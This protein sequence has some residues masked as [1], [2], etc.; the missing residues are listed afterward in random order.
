MGKYNPT[1]TEQRRLL[2]Q[3]LW[4]NQNGKCKSCQEY[5]ELDKG[6]IEHA[7]GNTA[8][9]SRDNITFACYSC[10]QRKRP[11]NVL[12]G[13]LPSGI[14]EREKT[15]AP[16]TDRE[17][18]AER[19]SM[20]KASKEIKIN[21]DGEPKFRVYLFEQVGR[22][23]GLTWDDAIAEGAE[24]C[25]VSPETIADR[26][27]PKAT[28]RFSPFQK[29]EHNT[30]LVIFRQNWKPLDNERGKIDAILLQERMVRDAAKAQESAAAVAADLMDKQAAHNIAER[31]RVEKNAA[32]E[33]LKAKGVSDAEIAKI[34]QEAA[35]GNG[36]V[37][38]QA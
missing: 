2:K 9:Y 17:V 6:I 5:I 31:H 24:V 11:D 15:S 36:K 18:M 32:I 22:P 37:G 28:T 38:A 3:L 21:R 23:N 20:L 19:S 12:R 14:G 8:D 30:P 13:T 4:E 7:N 34:L 29:S 1:R 16:T 35:S 10:N 26:W 27:L 33:A 25:E